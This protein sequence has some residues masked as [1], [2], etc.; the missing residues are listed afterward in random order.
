MA[1]LGQKKKISQL[2]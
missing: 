1:I 2:Q